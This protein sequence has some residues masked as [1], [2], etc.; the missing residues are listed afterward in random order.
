[1]Y[2]MQVASELAP[3]AKVGGLA[4]VVFGLS[5]ELELRGHAVEISPGESAQGADEDRLH[6]GGGGGPLEAAGLDRSGGAQLGGESWVVEHAAE[7]PTQGG[8]VRRTLQRHNL[9]SAG[10]CAPG[11]LGEARAEHRLVFRGYPERGPVLVTVLMGV[12]DGRLRLSDAA[13]PAD[14]GGFVATATWNAS[15]SVGH[16]GHVHQRKNQYQAELAVAPLDGVWKLVGLEILQ[17]ERL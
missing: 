10:Q 7:R 8:A 4:D 11:D 16:W 15:G 12:F 6:R 2:I 5:R 17:E 14:G 13:E 1:M 3:V 9:V